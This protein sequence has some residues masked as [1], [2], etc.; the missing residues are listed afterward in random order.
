M[1]CSRGG[2]TA[3]NGKKLWK[4]CRL[5]GVKAGVYSIDDVKSAVFTFAEDDPAG[6][7]L[8]PVCVFKS[9]QSRLSWDKSS[10]K[11]A[12]TAPSVQALLAFENFSVLTHFA[13]D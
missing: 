9:V 8:P 12:I 11:S 2:A 1:C 10:G 13:R 6:T 3:R 5:F 4:C 7:L